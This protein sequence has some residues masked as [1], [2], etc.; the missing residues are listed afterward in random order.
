MRNRRPKQHPISMALMERLIED[1]YRP[2]SETKPEP[3]PDK[4]DVAKE[5]VED[6]E[7]DR[8]GELF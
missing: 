8:F 7:L 6:V 2:P 3:M 5:I 4:R 1:L